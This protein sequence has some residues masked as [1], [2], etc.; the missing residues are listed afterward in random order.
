MIK[1]LLLALVLIGASADISFGTAIG[2]LDIAGL[3]RMRVS[4][5]EIDFEPLGGGTGLFIVTGVDGDFTVLAPGSDTGVITDLNIATAPPGPPLAVPI[6]PFVIVPVPGVIFSFNLE[7]IPLGGGP[8]CVPPP[9]VGGS[10]S[11]TEVVPNTPFVL[12]QNATGVTA[13]FNVLGTVTDLR[14][15]SSV[16]YEGLFTLQ[17]TQANA[18]TVAEV[19]S[20]FGPGGPGFV[21]ASWSAQFTSIPEPGPVL[22]LLSGAFLLIPRY[23]RKRRNS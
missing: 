10:C 9:P 19:L 17:F 11:P 3:G 12:T 2:T 21:Q 4:A 22:Y 6:D 18:D 14:D 8:S 16:P 7:R 5:M 20:A 1:R 23:L 15:L 13:Q